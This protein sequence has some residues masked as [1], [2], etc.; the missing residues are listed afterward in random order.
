VLTIREAR[1]ARFGHYAL[2]AEPVPL[3][4]GFM[5]RLDLMAAQQPRSVRRSLWFN[6]L[7][8]LWAMVSAVSSLAMQHWQIAAIF[9]TAA[10]SGFMWWALRR[11]IRRIPETRQWIEEVPTS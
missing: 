3:K 8:A 10:F 6:G 4:L 5:Q 9:A 11:S 2:V 7:F 1:S